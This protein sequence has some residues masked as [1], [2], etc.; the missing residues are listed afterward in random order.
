LTGSDDKAKQYSLKLLSYRGRS[1]KEMEERLRKKGVSARGISSTMRSLKDT[2]LL[3]DL[4]LAESLKREALTYRML[5]QAGA[6]NFM[7]RRGIPRSIV[8]SVLSNDNNIDIDNAVKFV[9][10]KLRVLGKYPAEIAKRR[11]Y[12]LLLRRG[13]SSGTILKVLKEKIVKEED[14]K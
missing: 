1:E 9:D 5:S 3:N 12:N 13:Y 6:R 14:A 11:L 7:L 4:S 2:G 8:D 10:K